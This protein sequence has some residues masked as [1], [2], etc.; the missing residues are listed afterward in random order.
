VIPHGQ[1]AVEF[2]ALLGAGL[3]P[4]DAIRA[5]TI[6][7]ARAFRLADSVG[8]VKTGML[9]DLIAL[10]ADPLLDPSAFRAPSL[11]MARGRVVPRLP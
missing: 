11:V 8:Q 4:L 7:A 3:T 2:A 1:N 6:N 5:A 10:S 9:A